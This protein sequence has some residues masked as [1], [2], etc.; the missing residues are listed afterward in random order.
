[1]ANG[2]IDFDA[3]CAELVAPDGM[4]MDGFSL[5]NGKIYQC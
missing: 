4:P 5:Y 2:A 3:Q 1:M